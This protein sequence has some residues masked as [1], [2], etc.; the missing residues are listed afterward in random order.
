M[1]LLLPQWVSPCARPWKH[2][3]SVC[4]AALDLSRLAAPKAVTSCTLLLTWEWGNLH[5]GYGCHLSPRPGSHGSYTCPCSRI[6]TV[7]CF[8][9]ASYE[10]PL[11][12]P[13]QMHLQVRPSAKR[14][15][16]GHSFPG[17]RK[18][19]QFW[20]HQSSWLEHPTV[21][22]TAVDSGCWGS[23]W[24]LAVLTSVDRAIQR[25]CCCAFTGV[26]RVTLHPAVVLTPTWRRSFFPHWNQYMKSEGGDCFINYANINSK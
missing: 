8:M 11:L 7:S 25:L 3:S 22:A 20:P 6:Q 5:S 9:D 14:D 16:T 23:L 4:A 12:S 10:I 17:R 18:R 21:L 19:D 15:S 2:C 13:L 24:S 26:R 1:K